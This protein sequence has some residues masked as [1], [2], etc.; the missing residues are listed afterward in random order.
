VNIGVNAVEI[1][2]FGIRYFN[3][4]FHLQCKFFIHIVRGGQE[5]YFVAGTFCEVPLLMFA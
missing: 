2:Y 5:W 3:E 1:S 4:P